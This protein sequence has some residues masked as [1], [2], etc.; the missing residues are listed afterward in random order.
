M[1]SKPRPKVKEIRAWP[2]PGLSPEPHLFLRGI[3]GCRS[4]TGWIL[5]WFSLSSLGHRS[6]FLNDSMSNTD[7]P[8]ALGQSWN[9]LWNESQGHLLSPQKTWSLNCSNLSNIF[10]DYFRR[11][12]VYILFSNVITCFQSLFGE[13]LCPGFLVMDLKIIFQNLFPLIFCL[14]KP[15]ANK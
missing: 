2:D 5:I 11:L 4:A 10:C 14:S 13:H 1:R 9:G 15:Y 6:T 3:Q 12:F 8:L 7:S